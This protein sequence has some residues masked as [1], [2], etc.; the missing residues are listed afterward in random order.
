MHIL[1]VL[2]YFWR[3]WWEY[4]VQRQNWARKW[5]ERQTNRWTDRRE[6]WN[7]YLYTFWKRYCWV[8]STFVRKK[9]ELKRFKHLS[10]MHMKSIQVSVS[11]FM[12]KYFW[13][14]QFWFYLGKNIE[15]IFLL[16]KYFL[17]NL[18]WGSLYTTKNIVIP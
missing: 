9:V 7:S 2:S 11:L 4:I 8:W 17:L 15:H 5:T 3:R 1:S 12:L 13:S 6:S 16:K 10:N 14:D 18:W